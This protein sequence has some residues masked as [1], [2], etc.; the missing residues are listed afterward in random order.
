MIGMSHEFYQEV[1]DKFIFKVK[2]DLSYTEGD[3]WIKIEEGSARFGVSDFLQRRSGDVTF[4]D[5]PKK[6]GAVSRGEECFSFETIKAVVA[7]ASPFDG[8]VA[9]VNTALGENP[10]LINQD[11]YGEAWI[12][13]IYLSNPEEDKRHLLTAEQY[14][15]LMK[16]KIKN[17]QQSRK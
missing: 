12:A 4:V 10:E 6:G 13:L 17:E 5:L 8:V 2:K 9:E 14:F 11:P 15:E 3:V 7:M 1:V 16:S